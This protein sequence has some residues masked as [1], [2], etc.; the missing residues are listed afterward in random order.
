MSKPSPEKVSCG[1]IYPIV[2][3]NKDINILPDY[4]ISKEIIWSARVHFELKD[5]DVTV[6][7]VSHYATDVTY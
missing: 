1:A 6:Q 4:I 7:Y 5:D 3:W 2:D